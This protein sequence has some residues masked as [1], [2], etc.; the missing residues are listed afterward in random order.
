M[1]DRITID[2]K[3]YHGQPCIRGMRVPVYLILDLL[4]AG[5]STKEILE[6]YPYLE[7]EDIR[8]CIEYASWL[9]RERTVPLREEAVAPA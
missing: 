3:I 8:Q 5:M 2:P 6:A 1:L 9:T 7:E 4:A